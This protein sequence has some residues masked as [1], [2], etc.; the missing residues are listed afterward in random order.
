MIY[1]RKND[2]VIEKYQISF[3]K[4]E[5]EKLKK[6]IINKCSFIKHEEFESEY[7]PKFTDK[8]IKNFRYTSTGVEKE[9]FEETRT[10]YHYSY[11]EYQ[12][13]YLV[14]LINKLLNGDLKSIDEILNYD[15]SSEISIDDK[16]CSLNKELMEID[17]ED[18]TKK[19][20]KL[21]EL[22]VLLNCKNLNKNQQSIDPYYNRLVDLIKFN[23]I[24]L[25]QMSELSKIESFFEID[26]TNKFID[27]D[28]KEKTFIKLFKQN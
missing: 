13:P 1:F 2:E 3:D 23:L 7:S 19:K 11:D 10:I 14:E 17:S 26:L 28:S 15:L 9:Y 22:H 5:I 24:D 12:P 27:S 6:E 18:I 20:E 4:E 8:I 16:I 25:L 21:R